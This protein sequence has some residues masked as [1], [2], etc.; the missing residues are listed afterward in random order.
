MYMNMRVLMNMYYILKCLVHEQLCMDTYELLKA[1][2]MCTYKYVLGYVHVRCVDDY[3]KLDRTAS[4][5]K[6][7][8]NGHNG[9]LLDPSLKENGIRPSSG[10]Y[11]EIEPVPQLAPSPTP[12]L[13]KQLAFKVIPWETY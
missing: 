8:E 10:S 7:L 1:M 11:L 3:S 6:A 2:Y 13:K 5:E 9:S 4:S 12:S